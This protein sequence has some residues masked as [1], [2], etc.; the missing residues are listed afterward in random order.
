MRGGKGSAIHVRDPVTDLIVM[1][2]DKAAPLTV[3]GV[4]YRKCGVAA[5]TVTGEVWGL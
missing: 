5:I 4:A 1:I 2:R 3:K